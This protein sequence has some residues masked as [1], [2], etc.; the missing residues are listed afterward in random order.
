MDN[1][2][3]ALFD[4]YEQDFQQ[5]VSSIREKLEGNA[6][7]ERGEQRKAALRKVELELDEADEMVSQMEIEIQGIPQSLKP[8]YQTRIKAAKTD[9]Q[10]FKKLSKETHAQ[11]ARADL[12]GAR[13]MTPTMDDPYGSDNDRTR[14]LA[15]T[16]LLEDGS[17]RLADSQRIALETE[18][19]GADILR[20]L[21][22]QREQIQNARDTLQ[23]ADT[24]IDRASG[25]LKKM[26][27]R[28][29][30]QRV[31]TGAIIAV[32]IALICI[33]LWFKLVR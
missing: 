33:I 9:L 19:Q 4:S 12:L 24:S 6:K 17:R 1:S 11:L 14:L 22:G 29:Y 30:Q 5:I 31:V 7:N 18:E 32:L 28:M 21:R 8:S 26:I 27:R 15:G 25:T 2:P 16:E 3:T 23:R 10:R 20:S 13:A